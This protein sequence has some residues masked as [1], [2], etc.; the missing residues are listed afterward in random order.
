MKH[1]RQNIRERF[2]IAGHFERDIEPFLHAE[3]LHRLGDLFRTH[4]Q[5]QI[6]AHFAREIEAIW[7][8]V[9]DHDVTRPGAFADRN[10]HA[11]D[12]TRASDEHIFTDQI[13][14]ERSMHSVS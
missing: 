7:I 14:R 11:T 3:L 8:D 13:E 2:W 6:G 10:G 4:I 5:R 12:R 1:V 9:G